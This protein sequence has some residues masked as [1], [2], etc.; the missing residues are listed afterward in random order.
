MNWII[1]AFNGSYTAFQIPRGWLAD[2]YAPRLVLAGAMA[3]WSIFTAGTGLAFNE[4]SLAPTR[5]L[6]GA[7]AAAAF[8][9]GSCAMVR[10]AARAT[11][12][13]WTGISAFFWA[14]AFALSR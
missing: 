13:V 9:S 12:R 10:R 5:L 8:P 4:I 3:W 7:G 6:F 11:A 2:R 14:P 1:S